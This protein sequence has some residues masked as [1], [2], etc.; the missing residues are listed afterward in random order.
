MV[1]SKKL[2]GCVVREGWIMNKFVDL[3][4]WQKAHGF[5][6]EIYKLTLKFP[7][8]EKFGLT[9]QIRRSA[10]SVA[11]NIAEGSKRKTDRDYSHFLNISEGSLEE[12]KYYLILSRDLKYISKDAHDRLFVLAEE[13]GKL[14]QG[15]IKKL[16]ET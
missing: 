6:L 13:I 15:F 5:V 7:S 16:Y 11:A 4:V 12:V 9:Q 14:L 3:I 8:D 10:V 2:N 1:E